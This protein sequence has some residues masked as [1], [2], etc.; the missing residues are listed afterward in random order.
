MAHGESKAKRKLDM[1]DAH[2]VATKKAPRWGS[3]TAIEITQFASKNDAVGKDVQESKQR[4]KSVKINDSGKKETN[5][6]KLKKSQQGNISDKGTE[7]ISGNNNAIPKQLEVTETN[8]VPNSQTK[9][10]KAKHSS[11]TPP[12]NVRKGVEIPSTST[13]EGER[14]ESIPYDSQYDCI[15]LDINAP[16]HD[17]FSDSDDSDCESVKIRPNNHEEEDIPPEVVE[18][19]KSH[20]IMVK[21]IGEV[22]DKRISQRESEFRTQN[23][24]GKHKNRQ[25]NMTKLPSDTTIYR[26]GLNR[27]STKESNE[28]INRIS[29]FVEDIR[30]GAS[31]G[32]TSVN[33]HREP[34]PIKPSTSQNR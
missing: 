20:P 6:G 12:V 33:E 19:L 2:E 26:S 10:Q 23:Q 15:E 24:Q 28:I 4:R 22:V 3:S 11:K 18:K 21:Y 5:K 32:V 29:N 30:I 31:K 1:S 7:T 9:K 17:D 13:M 14:N 16:A 34:Q 25:A 27:D 8:M